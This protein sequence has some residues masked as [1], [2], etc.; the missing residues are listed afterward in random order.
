[1]LSNAEYGRLNGLPEELPP[2][3]EGFAML[4]IP[5]PGGEDDLWTLTPRSEGAAPPDWREQDRLAKLAEY[6]KRGYAF[7]PP[8]G[9]EDSDE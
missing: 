3:M 8:C 4:S 5:L 7:E 6:V 1:M 2:S 9:G